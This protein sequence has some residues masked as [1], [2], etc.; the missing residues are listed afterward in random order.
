[1]TSRTRLLAA[2]TLLAFTVAGAASG[3]A[4]DRAAQPTKV[5]KLVDGDMTAVLD[6]L[7][8]T[9]AQRAQADEILRRRAPGAEATLLEAAARLRSIS[10]SLDAELHAVL[11][12]GQRARLDS[13]RTKPTFILRRKMPGSGDKVI[14]DTVRP[15]PPRP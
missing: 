4:I 3:I 15:G 14:V 10:D 8:L 2:L 1:M 13:L 11:T 9:P 5:L 7:A 6:K 12:P